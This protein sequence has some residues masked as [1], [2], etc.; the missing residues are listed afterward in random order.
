MKFIHKMLRVC[1]VFGQEKYR[2]KFL[3]GVLYDEQRTKKRF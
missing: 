3:Q 1:E 2:T